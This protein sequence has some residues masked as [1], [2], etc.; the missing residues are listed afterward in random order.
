MT[1]SYRGLKL[2]QPVAD[3]VR[4][5]T[6]W[7]FLFFEANL[8]EGGK[9]VKLKDMVKET[10]E[11]GIKPIVFDYEE[12]KLFG[13]DSSVVRSF[14]VINSLD[15]G[16]L[17]YK[18]YRFVA[19]R[20]RQGNHMVERHIQKL[21]R[22]IPKLRERN[23][24]IQCFTIPVYARLL[25]EG[26]LARMLFDAF[27]L[28]PEIPPECIC[29]ELSADILY[30]NMEES[31]A[32]IE[33]LRAL[34][35]KI[36]ISE[37]GDE[38]CPVFRLSELEFDYAFLDEYAVETLDRDDRERV[39]KS[40][41]KFLHFLDVKVIA[42]GLDSEAKIDG[43]KVVGCDG[44]TTGPMP[45]FAPNEEDFL[46]D[47]PPLPE[48]E[49]E[50]AE[51][52]K[53]AE[54]AAEEAPAEDKP[55]EPLDEASKPAKT[56]GKVSDAKKSAEPAAKAEEPS[57]PTPAFELAF[58]PKPMRLE[59]AFAQIKRPKRPLSKKKPYH[60]KRLQRIESPM[61]KKKP[62]PKRRKEASGV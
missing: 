9:D 21:I 6:V 15:L 55:S 16:T 45:D 43:A 28:Y 11:S 17:T 49:A 41:V 44:Y 48:D 7:C 53:T 24:A 5:Q 4:L 46:P 13:E 14:M 18:Q 3:K 61:E 36:A 22:M 57:A 39:A 34:G 2:S 58:V 54:V 20:T 19:R 32:G 27:A 40:L 30:E 38:F 26:E 50:A 29:I 56:K 35:V 23:P 52:E 60:G 31:K 1:Q 8:R 42:P 37:V 62:I 59:R 12:V 25:K 33:E 51:S 10:I 47:L